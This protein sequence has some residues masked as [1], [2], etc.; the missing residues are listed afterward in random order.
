MAQRH[1][2]FFSE[3]MRAGL[4]AAAPVGLVMSFVMGVF[5]FERPKFWDAAGI[6][7]AVGIAAIFTAV[8]FA[9]G[10]LGY[11]VS[12]TKVDAP[13]GAV[14]VAVLVTVGLFFALIYLEHRLS[15][16]PGKSATLNE[17]PPLRNSN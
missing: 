6:L 4:K 13:N 3:R 14:I 11:R 16:Q 10:F 8:W 2:R 15:A 7:I 1:P 12:G 5:L 17:P 9:F